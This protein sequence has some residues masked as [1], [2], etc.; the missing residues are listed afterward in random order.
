MAEKKI[1]IIQTKSI[2]G[3]TK[4]QR[5]TMKALGL[6]KLGQKVEQKETPQILGMIEKVNHL[7]KVEK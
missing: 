2:I 5:R 4:R 7:I 1:K 3:S 6:T